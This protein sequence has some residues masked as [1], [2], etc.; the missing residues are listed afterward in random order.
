V[1]TFQVSTELMKN[2]KA[3]QVLSDQSEFDALQT[4]DGNA[5]FFGISDTAILYVTQEQQSVTTG[6]TPVDLTTELSA[7]LPGLTVSAKTFA[8]SQSA[9]TGE[10]VVAQ[11]V[12]TAED[13]Q[14]H[15][16]VLGGLSYAPG[17]AWLASSENRTWVP[18]AYDDTANPL[19]PVA[20]SYV[21]LESSQDTQLVP[22]LV[23]GVVARQTS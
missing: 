17:A 9:S 11:V 14:D 18:R 12:H 21:R 23:A 10:I 7:L 22:Y 20:L 16:F 15:L 19:D 4:S 2:Q 3:A 5:L 1:T 8:V 13:D 6:W